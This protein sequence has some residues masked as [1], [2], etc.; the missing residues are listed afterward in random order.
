MT[1]DSQSKT[2]EEGGIAILTC[3]ATGQ[4]QPEIKWN[5]S[6]GS[7]P[8]SRAIIHDA[9]LTILNTSVDDS[10]LYV[11]T[12]TNAVGSNSSVVLLNVMRLSSLLFYVGQNK[13]IPCLIPTDPHSTV[14]WTYNKTSVLPDG[15]V[16]DGPKKL[17][18][19]SAEVR[20]DGNYT[21]VVRNSSSSFQATGRVTVHIWYPETCS[22]VKSDIAD[23]SGHY[24][25]DPDGAQGTAPFD[26]FCNMTDKGGIGVTVVSHDTENRTHV[27]S[28]EGKGCYKREVTY[29]GAT[30][31]QLTVLTDA[32]AYCEQFISYECKASK[33]LYKGNAWWVSRDGAKMTYWGGA[34]NND[35]YCACGLMHTCA[36]EDRKC[37]CDANDK[38]WREDSGLLTNKSYLPVSQL[39]FG[40]TGSDSEDGYHVLGKLICYG[41]A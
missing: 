9:K 40:D 35:G 33:L 13:T 19:A 10:G 22:R 8:A 15:V 26:V 14:V 3:S 25:I 38:V 32:S 34:T 16:I 39:R 6:D 1:V 17:K 18:T 27:D 29:V 30:L 7:L 2:V 41:T 36:N 24:V 21:C 12:A 20:H 37:N 5:K 28:C 11:C 31:S 23:V 4:P